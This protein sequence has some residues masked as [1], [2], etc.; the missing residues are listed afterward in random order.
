MMLNS[1]VQSL[2]PE[3]LSYIFSLTF[4]KPFHIFRSRLPWLLGQVCRHWRAVAWQ[5][6][7]LWNLFVGEESSREVFYG[8][9]L[10]EVLNRSG[11]THLA[12]SLVN[13]TAGSA[14]IL[15]RHASRLSEVRLVCD[16]ETLRALKDAPEM[17][18]LT[19]L[20]LTPEYYDEDPE[21]VPFD[22][23]SK[24]PRLTHVVLDATSAFVNVPRFIL[25][26]WPQI[27]HLDLELGYGDY[28]YIIDILSQCLN[29]VS[30]TDSSQED[31][32]ADNELEHTRPAICVLPRLTFLAICGPLT[33][34]SYMQCPALQTFALPGVSQ[35][36]NF[37][38]T[39]WVNFRTFMDRSQCALQEVRLMAD[40]DLSNF[41]AFVS[42]VPRVEI[43]FAHSP[44]GCNGIMDNVIA[45]PELQV[46][47][48]KANASIFLDTGIHTLWGLEDELIGLS[49][50]I[51][52][53]LHDDFED[54][55]VKVL[56][57]KLKGTKLL[58]KMKILKDEGLDV[59]IVFCVR[60]ESSHAWIVK[61][62]TM[63]CL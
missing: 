58:K 17:S 7:S 52:Q 49:S 42:H 54:P 38:Q 60:W 48:L 21:P 57:E 14:S 8:P 50:T 40:D 51:L 11:N 41:L 35:C 31:A 4:E 37:T 6:P 15:A 46:L 16:F 1:P 56:Y 45:F 5:N 29:L 26:P 44:M 25:L 33:V 20:C 62:S 24:A 32:H 59:S 63:R 19:K 13:S 9:I 23:A 43:D 28:H 34:L 22:I 18:M 36:T 39:D 53:C 2:P 61:E 30:F 47:T 3:I 12:V 27:T 10:E 55:D